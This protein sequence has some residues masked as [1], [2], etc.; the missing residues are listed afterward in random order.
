MV[1]VRNSQGTLLSLPLDDI[2]DGLVL[3]E[4][5]GL[6]PV[7]ATLVSSSFAQMDGEQ[8]HSSRREARNIRIHLDLEPDYI[9]DSVYD[10]R[11]RLYT[12]FMP[13]TEVQLRFYMSDDLVVN[14]MGRIETFET[15]IF[16]DKPNAVISL[17]CY[18]PDFVELESV[19][20]EGETVETTD[21]IT[22]TL[23][24][25][26]IE[27]G[28]RFVLNVDRDI[29]E[30]AIY[31]QP[32]GQSLRTLDFAAVDMEAGDV[33]TIST[34]SGSKGATLVRSAVSTSVLYGVSPQSNWIEL[35]PGDNE[36]RVH[37]EGDEI[38]YT[39]EY[40]HRYGGL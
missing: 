36:L 24:D 15:N 6:D 29:T 7:K 33:L 10:L 14:I 27:T 28:I 38:P 19:V 17:L 18:D 13:K 23:P 39:I 26:T 32:E 4:V 2:S 9:A 31:H 25:G 20:V 12:F 3:T 11:K 1:E 8:Y 40:S 22:I 21:M 34:V 5:E 35:Q 16:S 37:A 30:F